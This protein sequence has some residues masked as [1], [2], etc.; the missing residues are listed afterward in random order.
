MSLNLQ[1]AMMDRIG[2]TARTAVHVRYKSPADGQEHS[3]VV[4]P[5]GS[6]MSVQAAKFRPG[7]RWKILAH[8]DKP[9]DIKA[10]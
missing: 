1:F 7:D 10:E 4:I 9:D 2:E 5:I 3:G 6:K 8:D